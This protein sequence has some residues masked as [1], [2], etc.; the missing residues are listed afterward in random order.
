MADRRRRRRGDV[1]S[2]SEYS[3]ADVSKA[4]IDVVKTSECVR[5][6]LHPP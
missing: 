4:S 1:T 5:D 6:Q 3:E 2:E